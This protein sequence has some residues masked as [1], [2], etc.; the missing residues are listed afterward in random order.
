MLLIN[1]T[2]STCPKCVKE[3]NAKIIDNNNKIH[4]L[5]KC[6]KHGTFKVLLSK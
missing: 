5:K 3:I 4:M 6:S 1:K 2:K